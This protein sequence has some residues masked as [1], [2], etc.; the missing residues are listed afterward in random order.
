MWAEVREE[1]RLK[2]EGQQEGKSEFHWRE[3]SGTPVTV[4]STD[5]LQEV[6]VALLQQCGVT[7]DSVWEVA[8]TEEGAGD[9]WQSRFQSR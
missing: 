2:G 9:S 7:A 3:G 8:E 5:L 4:Q 1:L 6:E